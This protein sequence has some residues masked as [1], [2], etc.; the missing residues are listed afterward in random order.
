M[1]STYIKRNLPA[2]GK[3]SDFLHFLCRQ[4]SPYC[5]VSQLRRPQSVYPKPEKVYTVEPGYNDTGLCEILPI[6]PDILWHQLIP[7][8]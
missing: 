1:S 8:F 2:T 7:H 4:D 5:L 3:I 6:A